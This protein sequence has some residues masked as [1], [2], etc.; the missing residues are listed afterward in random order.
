MKRLILIMGWLISLVVV[1]CV[2]HDYT[3]KKTMAAVKIE[4]ADIQ[5]ML[6]FNHLNEYREI[7]DR[8]VGGCAS[9]ALEKVR[10]DI[11][12][13]MKLLAGFRY[14]YPGSLMNKFISERDPKL[15]AQLD[16]LKSERRAPRVETKCIK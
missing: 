3:Q 1:A 13:E 14:E 7:E 12:Q 15:L 10:V 9:A 8:L 5:A 4:L 6:W 16:G 2:S 11:D